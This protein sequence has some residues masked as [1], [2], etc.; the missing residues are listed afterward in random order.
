M[1]K[2]KL[3]FLKLLKREFEKFILLSNGC[4]YY[5]RS[6]KITFWDDK[7]FC[8]LFLKCFGYLQ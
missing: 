5:T 3:R 8:K 1:G 4:F 2:I 6:I 7:P